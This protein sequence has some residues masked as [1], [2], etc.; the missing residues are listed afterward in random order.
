MRL[1][2][3][4]DQTSV[5]TA[6]PFA[7]ER[8]SSPPP[9]TGVCPDHLA[10]ARILQQL[11]I[12][13]PLIAQLLLR[14]TRNDTSIET[15]LLAS[16]AVRAEIYYEAL[17]ERLGL[18]FLRDIDPARVT[19]MGGIDTQLVRPQMVRINFSDRPPLTAIVPSAGRIL[20]MQAT[21]EQ[22]PTLRARLAVTTP[23]AIRG[24]VWRVGAARR[25]RTT[26]GRLFDEVPEHSA[27]VT[28]WGR[29]GFYT[30]AIVSAALFTTVL[31][32]RIVIVVLHLILSL[33]FLSALFIRL[34]AL[35]RA[36]RDCSQQTDLPSV[37]HPVYSVFVALY[38]EADVVAQLVSMLDR[39]DWPRS[40]LDIKLICEAD[41]AATLDA[42]RS[43]PLGP[44]YEI[45][46][47]PPSL[48]R[49]KPKALSYA[50]PAARGEY[51]VI[52]DAEDRPHPQQLAEAWARFHAAPAELACL[53]APLVI[54]NAGASWISALFSLEYAAL[55]RRLLPLLAAKRLPM[56]LGGTSN[57]FRTAALRNCG[58]WDP[59]NVTEDADLGLRLYRMGYTC[60]TLNLPTLEDAP[61]DI[62]S[63]LGQR[64]RWFKGWL[65][66]WLV[67]MRRPTL[68]V[69]EMGAIPFTVFQV[70]IGGLL[71]SSL[72]HP[73]LIAYVG[74]AVWQMTS[75]GPFTANGLL[76]WL[77]LIDVANIF[78][79]YAVFIALGRAP[80]KQRERAAVGWRWILVPFYWMFVSVAAWRALG[81]LRGNPFFWNKT[82][83][84][85]VGTRYG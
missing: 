65:Q 51:L 9:A 84:R 27:R 2:D 19:D 6:I 5:S 67:L 14:A 54:S 12:G 52:Y 25:S 60:A 81:E 72:A 30:G 44:Q 43:L 32:P 35:F 33:L 36:D 77:F 16:G 79:S 78:G 28:F 23:Q 37:P 68:L 22:S 55:F 71:L 76:L 63:W 69:S 53:Q 17:A 82:T 29:Q 57:H 40:R 75:D 83:H 21:L 49:T 4:P 59:H 10:E 11:G 31:V 64:T 41:D 1:A 7:V 61:E 46:E 50:L 13:K 8:P 62:H 18:P 3:Y 73:L 38:R 15:E 56:P 85:P 70:L 24:A 39:L 47:V 74:H 26:I 80:M 34:S 42:L 48:P 66:T 45:V 20:S 58:G